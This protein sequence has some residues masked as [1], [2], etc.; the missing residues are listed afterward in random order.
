LS[1][2]IGGLAGP[3]LGVGLKRGDDPVQV[4]QDLLVHLDHALVPGG[5]CGLDELQGAAT[6]LV[7][8]GQELR[9]GDEDRAGQAGF[10]ELDLLGLICPIKVGP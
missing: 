3:G 4:A 5:L 10:S 8:L 7:V 9:G 1:A 6:L 2:R